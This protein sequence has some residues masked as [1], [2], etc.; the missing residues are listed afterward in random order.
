MFY[1]ASLL[2]LVK[3]QWSEMFV[4]IL[5]LLISVVVFLFDF[6]TLPVYWLLQLPF[7]KK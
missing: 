6:L 5:L 4:D 3:F 7:R 1:L 2:S